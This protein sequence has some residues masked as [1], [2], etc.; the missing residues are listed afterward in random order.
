MGECALQCL[1]IGPPYGPAERVGRKRLSDPTLDK[2]LSSIAWVSY[3]ASNW[4]CF[5]RESMLCSEEELNLAPPFTDRSHF[6]PPLF[7]GSV[8]IA[9]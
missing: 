5:S 9:W 8:N 7:G 3:L 1:S 4:N 2:D 6:A